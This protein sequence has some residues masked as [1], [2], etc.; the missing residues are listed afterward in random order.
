[1]ISHCRSRRVLGQ[2]KYIPVE[3]K[4]CQKALVCGSL[5]VSSGYD[6]ILHQDLLIR[7]QWC[8]K[9]FMFLMNWSFI[10]VANSKLILIILHPTLYE[11]SV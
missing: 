9:G 5:N 10:S 3:I 2:F 8:S 1:M 4:I 11:L 6:A 7:F